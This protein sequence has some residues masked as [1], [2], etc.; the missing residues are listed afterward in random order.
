MLAAAGA[1]RARG[2]LLPAPCPPRPREFGWS[3]EAISSA[4]A[5]RPVLAHG[6]VCGGIHQPL[7]RAQSHPERALPG[8]GTRPLICRRSWRRACIAA[9]GLTL[10]LPPRG[11]PLRAGA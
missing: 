9:A 3:T 10:W 6:T 8:S 1:V 7:R 5:L 4:Q 11:A 2:V